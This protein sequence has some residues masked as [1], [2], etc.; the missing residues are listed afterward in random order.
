MGSAVPFAAA[1]IPVL[2]KMRGE[3]R[4]CLFVKVP[5]K[6]PAEKSGHL[7]DLQMPPL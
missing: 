4:I 5:D 6:R 3:N 2:Q 7:A 1:R